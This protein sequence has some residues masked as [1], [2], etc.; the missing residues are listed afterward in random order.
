M[1]ILA[2]DFYPEPR[3]LLR[4]S[5]GR[6]ATEDMELIEGL[7]YEIYENSLPLSGNRHYRKI[8]FTTAFA[9]QMQLGIFHMLCFLKFERNFAIYN[10]QK[11]FAAIKTVLRTRELL[12][13]LPERRH[14]VRGE[15]PTASRL[16]HP[17][18][19]NRRGTAT[20]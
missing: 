13:P 17:V 6:G 16:S 5:P 12:V 2:R 7:I 1:A 15:I 9:I 19:A 20:A 4:T 10:T 3:H 11:P 14:P 8:L 18:T